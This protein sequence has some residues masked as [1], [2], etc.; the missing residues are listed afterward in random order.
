[1]SKRALSLL[2]AAALLV[3]CASCAD[4]DVS[5]TLDPMVE[6]S[7][8]APFTPVRVVDSQFTVRYDP[9]AS[10]NPIT[11]TSPNNMALTPLLYEGLFVL[12]ER[13]EAEPVL[14]DTFST[15]DGLTYTI[16]IKGG[17]LFSD[18]SALTS[19]DVKYSLEQAQQ[20]GRFTGRLTHIA[21]I[22]APDAGTVVITLSAPHSRLPLLLDVP[23]I[24]NGSISSDRPPGTGPYTLDTSEGA[25]R[26]TAAEHYRDLY[27]AP[28]DVIYL[29]FCSD[30]EL[31]ARF[32]AQEIDLF[33]SDPGGIGG[34]RLTQDHDAWYYNTSI[35]QYVG[36]NMRRDILS[37]TA[38]RR[39]ISLAVNR[40]EIVEE[41]LDGHAVA[42]PLVL[43][44]KHPLYDSTWVTTVRDVSS[45]IS[46]IFAEIGLE[47]FNS[48]GYL[49]YPGTA[50]ESQPFSLSLLVHDQPFKVAA[51]EKMT[52]ALMSIGISV[53]LV[54]RPWESYLSALQRGQFDLY[55]ADVYLPADFDLSALLAPGGPLDYGH[56]GS[57]AYKDYIAAFLAARG[58][59]SETLA[60]RQ[61]CTAIEQNAPIIPVLYR[62]YAVHTSRNIAKGVSPTQSSIFY[63][64]SNWRIALGTSG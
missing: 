37:H 19:R 46:A 64:L 3:L 49:E 15:E 2:L 28:I 60:A 63:N 4:P 20:N 5:D 26:L 41:V 6:Y 40:A 24:K 62:Q 58:E 47:D 23:I 30:A 21:D 38:F 50:G 7:P 25:P 61:L 31:P 36:F 17:V 12:N 35:L 1:M 33:W 57:E 14:C 55:L 48:D 11:G 39:A 8:P 34:P 42:A 18:G 10:F 43:S 27:T 32:I 54:K 16:T 13:F 56:A 44:P 51:A 29:D 9:D 52:D 45:E 53:E 59:E 22:E